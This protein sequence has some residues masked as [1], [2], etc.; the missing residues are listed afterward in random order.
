VLG[1]RYCVALWCLQ[2]EAT[3]EAG[4]EAGPPGPS[5][6]LIEASA[7]IVVKEESVWVSA[8][9]RPPYGQGTA[10]PFISQRG[11]SLHA[12]RIIL[13]TCDGMADSATE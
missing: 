2:R 1:A 7:N 8:I 3:S 9:C 13:A 11:G 5:G 12:C 10:P 6:F 4:E